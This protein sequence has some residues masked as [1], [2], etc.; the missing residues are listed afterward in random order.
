MLQRFLAVCFGR[1]TWE[2]LLF[3]WDVH[4]FCLEHWTEVIIP[5]KER[6]SLSATGNI[7]NLSTSGIFHDKTHS[8]FLLGKL[9]NWSIFATTSC[10]SAKKVRSYSDVLTVTSS[11]QKT[12]AS[13]FFKQ[14]CVPEFWATH[15]HQRGVWRRHCVPQTAGYPLA[16]HK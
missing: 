15:Y 5:G 7:R 2:V 12:A 8:T 9:K 6:L 16:L 1:T 10:V 11:G 3:I 14:T 13:M 4:F